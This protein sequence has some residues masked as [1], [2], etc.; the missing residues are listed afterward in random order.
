MVSNLRKAIHVLQDGDESYTGLAILNGDRKL[1]YYADN[2]NDVR[3]Q[4]DTKI[5][6]F[7][8]QHYQETL[9]TSSTNYIQNSQGEGMLVHYDMLGKKAVAP[10][11]NSPL[12]DVFLL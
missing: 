12:N 8:D 3:A 6:E 1:N 4:I 9:A 5:L 2:S 11:T 7:V 10:S